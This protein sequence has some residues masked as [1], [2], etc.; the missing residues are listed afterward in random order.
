M[1]WIQRFLGLALPLLVCGAAQAVPV[2]TAGHLGQGGSAI[3]SVDADTGPWTS[4]DGWQFWTFE[5]DLGDHVVVTVEHL[6]PDLDPV[7]GVW[8]GTESDTSQYYDM[9]SDSVSST[10]FGMGDDGVGTLDGRVE[11]T[12][13]VSGIFT[14][15]V[16][17]HELTPG[18]SNDMAYRISVVPEPA[19]YALMLAGLAGLAALKRRNA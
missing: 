11:F 2:V 17:D 13:L 12:S 5:A 15:A 1:R 19:T 6:S 16:A 14:V 18:G 8:F 3:G 4:A 7:F 9:G 10:W